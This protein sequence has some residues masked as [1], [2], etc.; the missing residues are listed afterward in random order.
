MK[1]YRIKTL[2]L[3][4]FLLMTIIWTNLLMLFIVYS[5]LVTK[6]S[7]DMMTEKIEKIVE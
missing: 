6:K 5:F 4:H 7:H 2:V 3:N 1:E